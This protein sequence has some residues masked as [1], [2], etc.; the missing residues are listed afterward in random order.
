MFRKVGQLADEAAVVVLEEQAT[1]SHRLAD[2]VPRR[3][4]S[5]V[6]HVS[7]YPVGTWLTG[8]PTSAACQL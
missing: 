6:P 3:C 8:V 2:S 5:G 4:H 7:G 1:P